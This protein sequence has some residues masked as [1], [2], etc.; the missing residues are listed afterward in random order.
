RRRKRKRPPHRPSR[1]RKWGCCAR[2][3]TRCS[4]R[5]DIDWRAPVTMRTG[6]RRAALLGSQA[7]PPEP[8][9]MRLALLAALLVPLVAS[10]AETRIPDHALQQAA[11]LRERA[12]ADDTAWKVTESLTTEVG[13]RLAGSEADARAVAWAEAKFR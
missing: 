1:A 11:Q 6:A 13:P 8:V 4:S 7:F 3:A 10:A 9:R 5:A 2:S 12:L